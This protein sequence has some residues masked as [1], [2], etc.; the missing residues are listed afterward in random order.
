LIVDKLI[1][2]KILQRVSVERLCEAL[3][4]DSANVECMYGKC[5]QCAHRELEFICDHEFNT[6]CA[7]SV[8]CHPKLR[9]FKRDETVSY[10]CWKTKIEVLSDGKKT[11]TVV[12]EMETAQLGTLVETFT[13]M[14]SKAKRH[15]FNIRHQYL[16]YRYQRSQLDECSCMLHIDFAENYLCQYHREIQS[17]HF[18]GSHHQTTMRTGLLYV[19]Q[20]EPKP[21]CTLSDSRSHEPVAIW[22]YLAPVL[23]NLGILTPL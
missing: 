16:Q 9:P 3:A 8:S 19:G 10:F 20:L 14:L 4:C 1:D 15:I 12:K 5:N 21:F 2:L 7:C 23:K 17:V 11:G 22:M 18:G 6:P 13:D